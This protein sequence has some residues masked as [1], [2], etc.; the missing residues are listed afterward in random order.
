VIRLRVFGQMRPA[1][2]EE[3]IDWLPATGTAQAQAALAKHL[4]EK[5]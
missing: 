3:R 5:Q 4:D 1:E 2:I